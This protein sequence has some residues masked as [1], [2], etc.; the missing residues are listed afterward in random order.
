MY[1]IKTYRIHFRKEFNR[2]DIHDINHTTLKVGTG[3]YFIDV[4]DGCVNQT[5]PVDCDTLPDSNDPS[6]CAVN[7]Y[8]RKYIT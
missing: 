3:D 1:I 8:K 5:F 4:K 7:P 6:V 2:R